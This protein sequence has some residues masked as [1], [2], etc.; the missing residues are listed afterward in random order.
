MAIDVQVGRTGAITPV[1]RLEPVRVGGV[2][3]T[4]A[5]LHNEDEIRRK[6]LRVGGQ[7]IVRRAGDVIPQVVGMAP[8]AQA[9]EA[10]TVSSADD[11]QMPELCPECD[12][13]IVREQGEAAYRCSGGLSC[14]AQRKQAIWHFA[15][16]TAM[17]IDGLGQ[18]LVDQLVDAGLLASVADIY[19]LEHGQLAGLDR[20]ADKSAANLIA[21]IDNSR[22]TTLGRFIFALGIRHVGEAT[23]VAIADNFGSMIGLLAADLETLEQIADVGPVV[24]LSLREF[25]DEP[26]N[27]QVVDELLELGIQWP[28]IEPKQQAEQTLAGKTFVI[29]GTFS[30]PRPEI[31]ADL[32]RLGAKVTGSVSKKTDWVAVGDSPGSK[33]DKAAELGV[34]VIDEAQLDQLI[35][36]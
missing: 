26:H 3:V 23:G 27:R 11:F 25:L 1:A 22:Q 19:R 34:A 29:T 35:E 36:G 30:R 24:A 10:E 17:D 32:V 7:V 2:I 4:N 20:M 12:A 8:N 16:R 15:S 5:T 18:K 9:V 6:Q 31:K 13:V 33:A 28:L 14:P 21:A